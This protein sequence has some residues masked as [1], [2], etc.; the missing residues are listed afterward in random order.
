MVLCCLAWLVQSGCGRK[1]ER[2]QVPASRTPVTRFPSQEG[3]NSSITLTRAGKLQAVIRYG[4]MAEYEDAG[5]AYFDQGV[6]VDFF[7]VDGRHTSRLTSDRGEYDEGSEDVAGEGH[8]VVVSD[9]GITLK[10]ERL[11]WNHRT[12]KIVT[13]DR[14]TVTNR[15]GDT[16]YGLGFESNSDLSRWVIKQPRGLAKKGVN[17]YAI[18]SSWTKRDTV[19]QDTS[20]RR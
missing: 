10:T 16:L 15:Q 7:D 18:D 17:L 14:V 20:D 2:T 4:H 19:P 6:S 5:T 8:V 11:K 13:D 12:E 9:T 1:D 3:W